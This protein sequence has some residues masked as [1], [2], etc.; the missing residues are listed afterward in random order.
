MNI[1]E[2]YKYLQSFTAK[3]QFEPLLISGEGTKIDE[4]LG[5]HVA[6]TGKYEDIDKTMPVN[7]GI[8]RN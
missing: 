1:R 7:Q 2:S 4:I 8:W 6:Y 3:T 5:E